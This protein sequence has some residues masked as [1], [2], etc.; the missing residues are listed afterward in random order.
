MD[1]NGINAEFITDYEYFDIPNVLLHYKK[2]IQNSNS[3]LIFPVSH[4]SKK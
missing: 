3:A 2:S 4:K 1:M